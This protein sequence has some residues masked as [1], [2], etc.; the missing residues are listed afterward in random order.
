MVQDARLCASVSGQV[1][2][3]DGVLSHASTDTASP[4]AR[5]K[6]WSIAESQRLCIQASLCRS[7]L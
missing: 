7:V 5:D 6:G 1:A 2:V 4:A 3:T